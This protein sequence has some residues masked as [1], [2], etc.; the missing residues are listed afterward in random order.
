MPMA[1]PD[2]AVPWTW[3]AAAFVVGLSPW[4]VPNALYAEI[5]A[6]SSEIPEGAAIGAYVSLVIQ[7]C[8]GA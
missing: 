7:A 4:I 3:G 6:I 5:P 8:I 2:D 1:P